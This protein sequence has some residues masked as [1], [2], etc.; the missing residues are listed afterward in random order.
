MRLLK[1]CPQCGKAL[2]SVNRWDL[3]TSYSGQDATGATGDKDGVRSS[4]IFYRCGHFLTEEVKR[5]RDRSVS[6]SSIDGKM[7]AYEFQ[8]DGVDFIDR[9]GYNGLIVDEMGLGKTIQAELLLKVA[10]G[11]FK[12]TLIIVKGSTTW[13]W[14]Q[15]HKK[16]C[17]SLPLG[18]FLIQGSKS[19]IPPGFSCYLIGMD[20]LSRMV[21]PNTETHGYTVNKFLRDLGIDLIVADEVQ[22]FKNPDSRRSRALV[23]LIQELGIEH[24]IFLSGTPIKNRANEYFT[25]LNLLDP[26]NFPS[27]QRFERDWLEPDAQGKMSR[28]KKY[29]VEEFHSLISKYVIRRKKRDVQKWLPP[30]RRTF[31]FVTIED[32]S[33]KAVYNQQLAKMQ[34]EADAK[35]DLSYFDIQDNLMTLRR[36]TG[37]AKVDWAFDEIQAFLESTE[38][39][40]IVVG[41][42]HEVVRDTLYQK[43][44]SVGIGVIKISGEDNDRR[45]FDKVQQFQRDS[46]S[47]VAIINMLA[48]GV[49]IDGLQNVCSNM[50]CLERQWNAVDEEQFEARIDRDG[51]KFPCTARYPLIPGSIDEY[52]S[53]MVEKKRQDVGSTT[54]KEWNP[55]LTKN[56]WAELMRQTVRG[57]NCK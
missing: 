16:W 56:D 28:V 17:N 57:G 43:L 26:A 32:E 14:L 31:E 55:E 25:V 53:A 1:E 27:L 11:Y 47:R 49:G 20:T 6:L 44:Q 34:N 30:F 41:I 2:V 42:H 54:D 19:F 22:C 35:A 10:Q 9:T 45:K 48:G 29:K 3:V 38:D 15:Q 23:G 24:K 40:K 7:Q 46:N 51:Q 5:I 4:L 37:T 36:I 39:E 18:I 33:I 21:S 12:C 52:F 8:I 50:I 13:Q